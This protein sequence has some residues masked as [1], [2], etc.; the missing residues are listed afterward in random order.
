LDKGSKPPE[1]LEGNAFLKEANKNLEA[2]FTSVVAE[3]KGSKKASAEVEVGSPQASIGSPQAGLGTGNIMD[4]SDDK[5]G[6]NGGLDAEMVDELRFLPQEDQKGRPP[7]ERWDN[8]FYHDTPTS[9]LELMVKYQRRNMLL[10]PI[11]QEIRSRLWTELKFQYY[12]MCLCYVSFNV[13]FATN[14]GM[15]PRTAE[16]LASNAPTALRSDVSQDR[17]VAWYFIT[18]LGCTILVVILFAFYAKVVYE[19]PNIRQHLK[20]EKDVAAQQGGGGLRAKAEAKTKAAL[21]ATA[22][23]PGV[24]VDGLKTVGKNVLYAF[25]TP[26]AQV[27][28]AIVI[29]FI[30]VEAMQW[31][32]I[33]HV[34]QFAPQAVCSGGVGELI[35]QSISNLAWFS[36]ALHLLL[37]IKLLE[38]LS[39]LEW[40]GPLVS[41]LGFMVK[42]VARFLGLFLLC[43]AAFACAAWIVLKDIFGPAFVPSLGLGGAEDAKSAGSAGQPM[44]DYGY[45]WLDVI[46]WIFEPADFARFQRVP[47]FG[48][49]ALGRVIF[50]AFMLVMVLVMVSL[51]K[52]RAM[53]AARGLCFRVIEN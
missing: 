6:E 15:W 8:F 46:L 23:L 26:S 31:D 17:W 9:A 53:F 32:L 10:T 28:L 43:F 34:A 11:M 18:N 50:L 12:A 30:I 25:H 47:V 1:S 45:A 4:H 48:V 14:T 35:P 41:T 40:A 29:V 33:C 51:S 37:A 13:L 19:G 27:D 52:P 20:L 36:A 16:L 2:S 49:G 21:A 7:K 42:D 39:V 3:D 38:L 22:D 24:M 5:E 44:Y